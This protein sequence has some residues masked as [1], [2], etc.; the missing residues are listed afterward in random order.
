MP[1]RIDGAYR[2]SIIAFRLEGNEYL[3]I[4]RDDDGNEIN[5]LWAPLPGSQELWMAAPELE[6]LYEGTRGPGK[7]LSLLM[8]FMQHVGQGY[9]AAWRG[10]LFRRTY[11][12]LSDVIV[13]SKR[14]FKRLVPDAFYN[15][16]KYT[17]EFPDGERL[18]FRPFPDASSYYAYHGHSYPWV[19]WEEMTTWPD[20]SCFKSMFS[21]VRSDVKGIPLKVRGTTNPYGIGHNWVRA[22][23]QLLN[24]PIKGKILGPLI[25]GAVDDKGEAEPPRRAIH[26]FLK[27]NLILM[28]VD[29]AYVSRLRASARNAAE[30]AAWIDGSWDIAAGGMFD[31]VWSDCRSTIVVPKFEVPPGWRIDRAYDHGSTKPWSC[32]Y[33][34]TSDGTDLELPNGQVLATLRGD[35]FRVGEVYGWTGKENEGKRMPVADIKKLLIKYEIDQGWRDRDA[36]WCRVKRG[37]ADTQIFNPRDDGTPSIA[38]DFE[39]PV[40]VEGV[41]FP[42]IVW[43]R[44]DKGPGSREQGWEQARKRLKATKRPEGG[45]REQP[46]LFI[47]DNCTQWIRTVPTLPRDEKNLDDID[48]ESEDHI[49]DEMRYRLR[50]KIGTASFRRQ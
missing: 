36:T 30:L 4:V 32:G 25:T 24:W 7:T 17:W 8:D 6:V 38:D 35:L 19:G 9:G 49:G 2:H 33:Y 5:A 47:C 12:E 1:D 44:A 21:C 45:Y 41:R 20:A 50:F 29:P 18:S 43:E 27:E 10:I 46:G 42:G 15:E 31:D 26:G 39:K 13:M 22:R 40:I 48:D 28:K 14:W 16:I 3:P 34:A 37:P 11:P 23:Y